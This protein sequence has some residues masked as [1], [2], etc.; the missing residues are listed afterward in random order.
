MISHI[1]L[2]APATALGKDQEQVLADTIRQVV[3]RCPTVRGCR[4]GRRVRHGLPGYEQ[5]MS[6][7]YRY[8]LILDFDDVEGLKAYLTDPA[9]E[10]LGRMFGGAGAALGYDFEGEG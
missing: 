3:D 5:G 8:S 9:H 6:V 2:F 10:Q 7:D 4:M 1:V